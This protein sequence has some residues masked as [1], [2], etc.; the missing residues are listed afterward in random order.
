MS[1]REVPAGPSF[2]LKRRIEPA[3]FANGLFRPTAHEP[4]SHGREGLDSPGSPA[5][6]RH[7]PCAAHDALGRDADADCSVP[8]WHE[9]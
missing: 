2:P 8:S 4:G 3:S 7:G 5:A 9:Q 1:L 6:K